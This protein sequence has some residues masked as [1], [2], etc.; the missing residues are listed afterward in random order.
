MKTIILSMLLVACGAIQ[1]CAGDR[2]P[3]ENQTILKDQDQEYAPGSRWTPTRS[4]TSRA[5][6]AIYEF[7]NRKME[8]GWKNRQREIIRKRISSYHVQFL[9]IVKQGRKI[10]HC[11]FFPEKDPDHDKTR[12]VFVLDG[13]ASYW[14]IDYDPGK[15]LCF[16]FNVNGEA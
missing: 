14:R 5:L 11:N 10:I 2:I 6:E 13:G 7:L 4:Q 16:D 3:G 1:V 12:Y 15:N 8:D 9:G